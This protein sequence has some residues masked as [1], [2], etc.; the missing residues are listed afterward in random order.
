MA[1][2]DTFLAA[3]DALGWT[4]TDT[5]PALDDLAEHLFD[6]AGRGS[7]PWSLVMT[8]VRDAALCAED[9]DLEAVTAC[10]TEAANRAVARGIALPGAS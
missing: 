6:H 2:K 8:R 4:I 5:S 10:L 3:C 1:A 9:G 7:D